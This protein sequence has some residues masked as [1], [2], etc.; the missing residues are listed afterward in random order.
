MTSQRRTAEQAETHY[1]DYQPVVQDLQTRTLRYVQLL[2][3]AD[4][5]CTIAEY[6]KYLDQAR[7][8]ES[9]DPSLLATPHLQEHVTHLADLYRQ[10]SESLG[11]L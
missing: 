10:E 6:A 9:T 3:L 1:Q 5:A 8:M 2:A 11:S 4:T 7:E